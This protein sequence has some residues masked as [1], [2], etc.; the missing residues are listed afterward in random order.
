MKINFA[1]Y[2]FAKVNFHVV[3]SSLQYSAC[4]TG[5]YTVVGLKDNR[6]EGGKRNEWS[7]IFSLIIRVIN[8]HHPYKSDRGAQSTTLF[9]R[10][11]ALGA[12]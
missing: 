4:S 1:K 9:I 3:Q 10:L 6:T 8:K 11:T 7:P 12:Y 2:V 5:N